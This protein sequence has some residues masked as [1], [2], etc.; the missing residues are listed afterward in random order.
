MRAAGGVMLRKFA[1][2]F[3]VLAFVS[4]AVFFVTVPRVEAQQITL[5]SEDFEGVWPGNWSVTDQDPFNGGADYW[6]VTTYRAFGGS[7]S[8]WAAEVGANS[9]F[10]QPNNAVHYYDN[11]MNAWMQQP[12]TNPGN[13]E[14]IRLTFWL[15][16]DT[17]YCCDPFFVEELVG[18]F[19]N[20]NWGYAGNIGG[21][22]QV[23]VTLSPTAT[24]FAF[25]FNTDFSVVYEGVYV[26]DVE[27]VAES[28]PPT[29][30]A[31]PLAAYVASWDFPIGFDAWDN[32][33]GVNYV[34]LY[35]RFGAGTWTPYTPSWNPSGRWPPFYGPIP[36]NA[37]ANGDGVYE[38][39]TIGTDNAGNVEAAPTTRDA[40][41]TV[42]T[43]APTSS[44][45]PLP[46]FTNDRM[47]SLGVTGADA[48]GLAR[49]DVYL[50]RDLGTWT[51]FGSVT[52][53]GTL[54]L[55]APTDGL[56]EFY[57]LAQDRAGHGE[58]GAGAPDAWVL[59]DTTPPELAIVAPQAGGH[60]VAN[61]V[62]VIWSG[63]DTGSGI[64]KYEVRVD[65]GAWQDQGTE[66]SLL[67]RLADGKH[68][69]LV[70]AVDQAGNVR[71][72]AMEIT[73]DASVLSPS[74]PMGGAPLYAL[75]LMIAIALL[76]LVFWLWRRRGAGQGAPQPPAPPPPVPPG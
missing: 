23:T 17:E 22:Q 26:D 67:V 76:L 10:G 75:F 32:G 57:S 68:V 49:I 40:S 3:V 54:A 51:W 11:A 36:F 50:R 33:S 28:G 8:A 14:A 45:T 58:W 15:W 72:Q 55:V 9:V 4:V 53:P 59:V 31:Q 70:R 64:A 30:E 46:E 35:F 73:V 34:Q 2:V 24:A 43:I 7:Q 5:L 48:G 19:W 37:S 61:D 60:Y 41:T 18:G 74:G 52:A 69:I 13:V 56:Y 29:T 44:V 71:L 1:P 38:F 21:W 42:D 27:L 6:G 63:F 20:T 12:F 25:V 39:Y 47:I 16:Q 62:L 65:G 66:N